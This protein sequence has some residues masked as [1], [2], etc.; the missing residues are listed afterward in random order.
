MTTFLV[1]VVALLVGLMVLKGFM[2]ANPAVLAR[3][4]RY[5]AGGIALAGAAVLGARG[6]IF[7]AVPLAAFGLKL[8]FGAPSSFFRSDPN[9]GGAQDR[10]ASRI[11]TETLEM[12]LDLD[13]GAMQGRVLKGTFADQAIERLT[14]A[15][16]GRL[17]RDCR[18]KD[19]KSAK[20]IEAYLDRIHPSWQEDM[21]RA[22]NEPGA[23]GQMTREEALE[24]L[25]LKS[26]ASEND[27]RRTHRDLMKKF[28]PDHGGS[29]YL[30][31]KINEAKETLVSK[32]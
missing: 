14:P 13:T 6:V 5:G 30:A 23:G 31:S 3:Q 7:F 16:L 20:L 11:V 17:W 26:G 10:K 24:I 8:L 25:G 22:D 18:F 19:P 29:D 9:R 12:E 15:E 2:N 1:G 21:S 32:R 27:I 28:H 4:V